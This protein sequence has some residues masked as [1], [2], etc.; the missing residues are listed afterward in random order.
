MGVG[1][2]ESGYSSRQIVPQ[3]QVLYDHFLD[4]V[5]L[6]TPEQLLERFR[7]LFLATARYK[8]GAIASAVDELLRSRTAQDEF[9]FVL[10]RCCHILINRWQ[11]NTRSG[12]AI[13]DLIDLFEE[14]SPSRSIGTAHGRSSLR[15]RQVIRTFLES[16]QYLTLKRLRQV[17]EQQAVS[18]EVVSVQPL[19][20]YIRRYP[21]LYEHCLLGDES[22][23]EQQHTIRRLQAQHQ[24]QFELQLSQYVLNQVRCAQAARQ[25]PEQLELVRQRMQIVAN[26]TLLT[27]PDLAIAVRHF[28]GRVEAGKTYKDLAHGFVAHHRSQTYGQF[29]HNLYDY[30][31]SSIDSTYGKRRFNQQLSRQLEGSF[32]DLES[33][34]LSDFLLVRTCGQL[35]NLLVVE[36]PNRLDHVTFVD[37]I[38]NLGATLTTGLL[39]K[40]LLICSKVKPH[41]E[42]RLSVLFNHY[43]KATQD[44][45]GWL[46]EVL[47]NLNIAFSTNFGNANL[48]FLV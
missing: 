47:E 33:K 41:L 4:L 45:V 26:P 19:G 31:T 9:I 12:K 37:L 44:S 39:L 18:R 6:E 24:H 16:E 28:T 1:T 15:M 11:L 32:P 38:N 30:L 7:A 25:G 2:V 5:D 48:S 40:L 8:E 36:G 35:F 23:L 20:T 34:P 21:Y 29:K 17:L 10:N 27:N 13:M 42:K 22:T 46:V 14:A 43:E 3:E